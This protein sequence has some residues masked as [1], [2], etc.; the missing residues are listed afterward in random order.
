MPM[1]SPTPAA[2]Q[3]LTKAGPPTDDLTRFGYRQELLRAMPVRDLLAY[4]LIFMV[5]IAPMAIF[6]SVFA[7]SGGMVVLAYLVGMVALAFTAASY[8]QLVKAFRLSGSVDNYVG[9]GIGAPLGFVA[10]WAVMIDYILV[11]SLL[12]LVAA[13]AMNATVPVVPVWL[14]LSHFPYTFGGLNPVREIRPG[15][16]VTVYTEDCFGGAVDAVT[17]QPSKKC[18][19]PFLNPVTGPFHV[20]GAEPGDTLAVHFLD[21]SPA[22]DWGISSFC[23]HFGA[24]VGTHETPMLHPPLYER[25]WRYDIDTTAD[26][27]TFQAR[28]SDRPL[29]DAFRISQHDMVLWLQQLTGLHVLDAYQLLAQAGT[30]PV[31][32]AVDPNYSMLARIPKTLLQGAFPYEGAPE[33]LRAVS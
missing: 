2:S 26:T 8:T 3:P 19:F 18:Q 30:A 14:W 24:L 22:R 13:V 21:I 33:R 27:V 29:E 12:Y 28:D 25:V 17:D 16:V 20:I 1:T 9:R 5:P 7:T 32:N 31:G 15:D 23:P 11:P 4:G 6:G 10:G